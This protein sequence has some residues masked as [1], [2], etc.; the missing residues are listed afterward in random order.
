MEVRLV[1]LTHTKPRDL[2]VL[3]VSPDGRRTILMSDACGTVDMDNRTLVFTTE[4]FLIPEMPDSL[5]CPSTYYQ[6]TNHLF[7]DSWPAS[8]GN[9]FSLL[10]SFRRKALD[11]DWRL[12]VVDDEAGD[13][14]KITGWGLRFVTTTADTLVPEVGTRGTASVYPNTRVIAPTDRVV[15]D[16]DVKV[17]GFAHDRPDD[18]D[19]LLVGPRGQKVLLLSDACGTTTVESD[20]SFDDE[21]PDKATDE[22]DSRVC[23]GRVKPSDFDP[24]DS[25]PAPAPN[26]PYGNSLGAFDGTEPRGEWQLYA[27][28]DK[29]EYEGYLLQPYE[30]NVD[31]RPKANVNFAPA[32]VRVPE[33]VQQ[34]LNIRRSATGGLGAGTVTVT[35]S[36]AS[37]TAGSDF[38]SL[39]RRVRFD[40]GERQTTVLVDARTDR[41][42]EEAETY[43]VSLSD[44]TGDAQ[45]GTPVRAEIT[46][47]ANTARGATRGG[48][49]PTCAGR[50]ATIV[51]T[52]RRDVLR[53]TRRADVIVA[54]AGNDTVTGAGGNDVVC[55]AG[56]NDRLAGGAGRDRLDGG[57]GRDR[58]SGGEGR[59]TCLGGKGRDGARCERKSGV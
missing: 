51:G 10:R 23:G 52:A 42:A 59:D 50:Q 22:F 30:L 33:G 5:A 3:L 27:A 20:F 4:T 29:E 21:A 37:A 53:G 48:S 12:S 16:V 7:P 43:A 35:T 6:P 39:S 14:G 1:G 45:L 24:G 56:G 41:A 58:L 8:P 40:R 13:S 26:G 9:D 25:M 55:G 28:D 11:G 15:S 44:P 2:D 38:T 47:P 34:A 57:P 49:A 36:P 32:A 46:I 31:T 19:L 54:L 17:P 18:V